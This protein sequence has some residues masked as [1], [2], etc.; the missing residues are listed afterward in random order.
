MLAGLVIISGKIGS[1]KTEIAISL[2]NLY[3][4]RGYKVELL[5]EDTTF[6]TKEDFVKRMQG[7]EG[8]LILVGKQ[9]EKHVEDFLNKAKKVRYITTSELV[10]GK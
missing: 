6:Y 4:A 5:D 3:V 7:F 10:T 8:H 2:H 1:G 9:S